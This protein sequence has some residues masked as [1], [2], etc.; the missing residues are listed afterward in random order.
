M[1]HLR[2]RMEVASTISEWTTTRSRPSA[3]PVL[4]SILRGSLYRADDL[5]GCNPHLFRC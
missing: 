1:V 4:V 3:L 5:L 2:A